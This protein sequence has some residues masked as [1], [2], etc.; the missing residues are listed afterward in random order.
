MATI[1]YQVKSGDDI[2]QISNDTLNGLDSLYSILV[3]NN[4]NAD[5][6]IEALATKTIAVNQAYANATVAQLTI[7]SNT[8]N[9]EISIKT[10]DKQSIYD[11]C[12]QTLGTLD[13]L[14]SFLQYNS[15]ASVDNDDISMTNVSFNY[16]DVID[17]MTYKTLNTKNI[18]YST[19]PEGIVLPVEIAY[20]LLNTRG[21]I[22]LNSGGRIIINY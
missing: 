4:L 14:L 6:D 21:Y 18:K 13:Q 15:I 7:A 1:N 9:N 5:S 11:V 8:P 3:L 20:L 16:D 12:N 10:N 19:L 22:L 2:Y 17:Y